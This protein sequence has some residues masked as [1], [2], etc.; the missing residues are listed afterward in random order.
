[1]KTRRKLAGLLAALLLLA[2]LPPAQDAGLVPTAHAVTQKEIDNLGTQIEK[3]Q[4]KLS[5]Q[6]DRYTQQFSR[7]EQL[8]NQMNSQSSALAGMMGG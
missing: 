7:L 4:D 1:M 6:V 5:N 2:L 8:I 3:W